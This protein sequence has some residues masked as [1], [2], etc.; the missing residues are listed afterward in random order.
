MTP[1]AGPARFGV[2]VILGPMEGVRQEAEV[3]AGSVRLLVGRVS[4]DKRTNERNQL[5]LSACVGISSLHAALWAD[6]GR[7]YLRDRGSRNGTFFDSRRLE[8][9]VEA[10]LRDGSL[11][12]VG[13]TLLRLR[14]APDTS[15]Q[16]ILEPVSSARWDDADAREVL[17][18]M[19]DVARERGERFADSRHLAS[20]LLRPDAPA[21]AGASRA[22]ASRSELFSP[23]FLPEPD[24]WIGEILAKPLPLPGGG[25][26][27]LVSPQVARLLEGAVRSVAAATP[28]RREALARALFAGLLG[29][30]GPVGAWLAKQGITEAAMQ[31]PLRPASAH[32]GGTPRSGS[33]GTQHFRPVP[34]APSAPAAPPFQPV[35][36]TQGARPRAQ[37]EPTVPSV[38]PARPPAEAPP[39]APSPRPTRDSAGDRRPERTPPPVELEESEADR[40]GSVGETRRPGLPVPPREG[41][42]RTTL[43]AAAVPGPAPAPR[44]TG[45]ADAPGETY[46]AG[47]ILPSRSQPAAPAAPAAAAARGAVDETPFDPRQAARARDLA[48]DLVAAASE[49]R[50]AP[51]EDRRK[52]LAARVAAAL[53]GMGSEERRA[54]LKRAAD[55]FPLLPGASEGSDADARR[56]RRRVEEL[57]GAL[58]SA[59][60]EAKRARPAAAAGLGAVSWKELL[61]P[62]EPLESQADLAVLR[63]IVQFSL[64]METFLLGLV[65]STTASAE[66]SSFIRLP[67]HTQTLRSFLTDLEKGKPVP[68]TRLKRYLTDMQ[69]WTI[70]CVAGYHQAPKEW[71][72]KFWKRA[73]PSVIE[74]AAK[75]G[76]WKIRSEE[77]AWWESY[78]AAVRDLGPDVMQDQVLQGVSKIA[79]GEFDRLKKTTGEK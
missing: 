4:L 9:E 35:E 24:G 68:L 32:A 25:T 66:Q 52:V 74:G 28:G 22:S 11:F 42:R 59:R 54:V 12:L 38:E 58:E 34:A 20:A 27:F 48:D 57:E 26:D 60:E 64:A 50:F 79:L 1:A 47:E 17:A 67:N 8:P 78:R 6:R 56:L 62:D 37:E 29:T 23:R 2:E 33:G 77:A 14:A 53:A 31:A 40:T 71:F 70:A 3:A 13:L 75:P 69:H 30:E 44:D 51:A 76:G 55:H 10:E 41:P 73:S 7:I 21:V 65:A 18:R 39:H 43:V 16:A 61:G 63:E 36:S 49:E 45:P 15:P 19:E 46:D 72:E 5:V